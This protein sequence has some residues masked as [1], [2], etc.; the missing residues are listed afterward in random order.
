VTSANDTVGGDLTVDPAFGV[1]FPDQ[2]ASE[3]SEAVVEGVFSD[4][5][6]VM[7]VTHHDGG[8]DIVAG[9]TN[10]TFGDENVTVL[11]EAAIGFPAEYTVR[12]VPAAEVSGSY[13]PGDALSANTSEA[14]VATANATVTTFNDAP[15]INVSDEGLAKDTTGDGML[16]DVD[17]TGSFT[18]FD[19]QALFDNRD[20]ETF[21]EHAEHF[22][23]QGTNPDEVTIFDVQSLFLQYQD[24]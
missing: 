20:T 2:N 10:G 1:Q 15:E 23:F 14:A 16:N 13:Q 21:T 11:L 18:I 22:N 6:V 9:M 5:E 8:D 19:V 7:F 24:S 3:Q 12:L 17:G 4:G